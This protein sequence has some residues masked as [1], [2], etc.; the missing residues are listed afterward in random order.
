MTKVSPP[1]ITEGIVTADLNTAL[2]WIMFF[3]ALWQGDTGTDWTPTFV[4]MGSTGTPTYS[5]T[6]FRI[7]QRLCYFRI[8][9]TPATDTSATAGTT[10][11][12]N[13]PLTITTDGSCAAVSGSVGSA[14]SGICV[15]STNRIYVPGWTTI[16]VP[17]TITGFIEAK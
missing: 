7:G 4:S 2:P 5:G 10:Y 9:V 6:V 3:N 11:C 1:P 8:T 17:V 13:F 14:D 12:D 15:A 16:T